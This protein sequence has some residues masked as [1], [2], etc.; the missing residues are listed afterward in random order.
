[1]KRK[2]IGYVFDDTKHTKNKKKKRFKTLYDNII[3]T[4]IRCPELICNTSHHCFITF[5]KQYNY[6]CLLQSKHKIHYIKHREQLEQLLQYYNY[7]IILYQHFFTQAHT[8]INAFRVRILSNTK[9]S[10][11]KDST[12][13]IIKELRLKTCLYNNKNTLDIYIKPLDISCVWKRKLK[14]DIM[15][16]IRMNHD[17]LHNIYYIDI[18]S[19]DKGKHNYMTDIGYTEYDKS[20]N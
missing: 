11:T 5:A 12:E 9:D 6:N 2:S 4:A 7:D 18:C 8:N 13:M 16:F 19:V 15:H 14:Q 1:M 3:N 10:N 17:I 20:F